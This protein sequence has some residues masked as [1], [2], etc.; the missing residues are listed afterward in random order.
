MAQPAIVF[1]PMPPSTDRIVSEEIICRAS[2]SFAIDSGMNRAGVRHDTV[3]S[4]ADELKACPPAGAFTHFHSAEAGDGSME[5]QTQRFRDAVAALPAK[6][7]LLHTENSAAIA[8]TSPSP[9]SFV[10][11]GVFLYGVGSGAK[12]QPEIVVTFGTCI[13]DMHDVP[14]G[15]TVSYNATWTAKRP[16]RKR[17]A[18]RGSPIPV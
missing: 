16:T 14:T 12:L 15:D 13:V 3:G 10:R 7:A 18:A 1:V 6:P 9:W 2:R 8:R 17:P 4:I 5:A 11:P